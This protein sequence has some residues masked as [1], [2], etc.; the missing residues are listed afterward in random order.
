[1]PDLG[2]HQNCAVKTNV[3]GAFGDKFLPPCCLNVVFQL[4][5]QRAVVPSV[6]KT[7]V[8]FTAGEDETAVFAEGYKFVHCEFAFCHKH[9]LL[10]VFTHD[11]FIL[12]SRIIKCKINFVKLSR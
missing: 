3:V 4:D 6:C 12:S 1:M 9:L 5:T 11:R 7:A 2:I 10:R 8:D